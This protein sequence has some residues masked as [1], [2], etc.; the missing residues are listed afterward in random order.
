M[1]FE[2]LNS[3]PFKKDGFQTVTGIPASGVQSA[4][5]PVEGA[6]AL[7]GVLKELSAKQLAE[8]IDLFARSISMIGSGSQAKWR[9]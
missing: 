3:V 1:P 9:A 4:M 5:G 2:A 8:P 7:C 6:A